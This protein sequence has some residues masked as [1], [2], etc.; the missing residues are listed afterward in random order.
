MSLYTHSDLAVQDI[1]DEAAAVHSGGFT[2]QMFRNIS[3]SGAIPASTGITSVNASVGTSVFTQQFAGGISSYN[4][5]VEGFKVTGITGTEKYDVTFYDGT[6]LATGP[7][8]PIRVT[9]SSN[10]AFKGLSGFLNKAGS[11]RIKF[12][13]N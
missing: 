2:F 3:G 13:G 5:D 7:T 4:N 11:V 12:A 8:Q 6:D 10:G 9:A 1:T